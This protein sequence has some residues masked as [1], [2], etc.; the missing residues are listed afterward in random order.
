MS[1]AAD[2]KAIIMPRAVV[3]NGTAVFRYWIEDGRSELLVP[4]KTGEHFA[5]RTL[6]QVRHHGA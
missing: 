5:K 2:G 4:A 1:W 3:G 6:T